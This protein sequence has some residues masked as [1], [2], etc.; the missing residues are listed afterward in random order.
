M[1]EIEFQDIIIIDSTLNDALM[2][3]HIF[4]QSQSEQKCIKKLNKECK[5]ITVNNINV[6]QNIYLMRYSIQELNWS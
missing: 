4:Y 2:K 6:I 1:F 3:V 5:N